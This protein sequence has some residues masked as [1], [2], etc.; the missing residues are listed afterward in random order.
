MLLY[1]VCHEVEASYQKIGEPWQKPPGEQE[2]FHNDVPG[3]Y[4]TLFPEMWRRALNTQAFHRLQKEWIWDHTLHL[5][6]PEDALEERRRFHYIG[7]EYRLD[8]SAIAIVHGVAGPDWPLPDWVPQPE[9]ER[10]WDPTSRNYRDP[11]ICYWVPRGV[12]PSTLW[13]HPC[14]PE[15]KQQRLKYAHQLRT[16]QMFG[17][18]IESAKQIGLVYQINQR[19]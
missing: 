17:G 3:L 6:V 9:N 5:E 2:V 11:T 1:R 8:P 18:L 4:V 10:D 15:Q 19:L 16:Q 7:I 12:D 14:Q 13:Y